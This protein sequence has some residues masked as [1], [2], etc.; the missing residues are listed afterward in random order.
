L[1]VDLLAVRALNEQLHV[2]RAQVET[3]N[4]SEM[5]GPGLPGS[6]ASALI[7]EFSA[8]LR[9]ARDV[10]STNRDL[11]VTVAHVGPVTDIREPLT[12]AHYPR[13][14]QLAKQTMLSRTNLLIQAVGQLLQSLHLASEWEALLHDS[15]RAS[16]LEQFRDGHWRDAQLNAVISVFDLIRERTGLDDDGDSL[17]T[18]TFGVNQPLLT[19]ADLTTESGRNDQ[20][21]LMLILQGV[22]RGIRNPRAHSLQHDLTALKAAQYLVLASLLARRVEEATDVRGIDPKRRGMDVKP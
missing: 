18:R 4:P 5:E 8:I 1:S 7:G 3:I 11:S 17:A 15:V 12:D 2:F 22:Y 6:G 14:V 20:I 21:G 10:L 19:V 16:A 13:A 9:T